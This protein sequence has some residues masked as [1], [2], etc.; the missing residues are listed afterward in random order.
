VA[1]ADDDALVV[2]DAT[3][4]AGGLP[5]DVAQSDVYFFAPQKAFAADGGLWLAL[6]SPAAIARAEQIA[7]SGL[8]IRAF[9]NLHTAITNARKQ[10]TYN[11]PAVSTL[12]LIDQQVRWMLDNGGLDW[13]TGRTRESAT[14]LY[15]WAE[16]ST[17]ATPFVPDPAER[18]WVVGTIDVDGVQAG[19]IVAAL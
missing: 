4:G 19:D 13:A 3:S 11:T 8:Y 14:R 15:E 1:G 2:V 18:S 16:K 7:A 6:V 17:F 5:V 9:L 10:Q 12:F